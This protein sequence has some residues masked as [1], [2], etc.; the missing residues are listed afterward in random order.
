M[1]HDVS[2][3]WS[4][5]VLFFVCVGFLLLL[6]SSSSSVSLCFW[7]TCGT[8][9]APP[10]LRHSRNSFRSWI[11]AKGSIIYTHG[12]IDQSLTGKQPGFKPGDGRK[13]SKQP[14]KKGSMG[15]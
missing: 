3:L 15:I 14:P 9:M 12:L 1:I 6:L 11:G 2:F 5:C 8:A 7:R 13:S 10:S 4:V